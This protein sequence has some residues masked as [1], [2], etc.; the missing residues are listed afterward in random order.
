MTKRSC[1][2]YDGLLER[3]KELAICQSCDE[4]FMISSQPNVADYRNISASTHTF[5]NSQII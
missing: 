5:L 4:G 1:R 3:R 2:F